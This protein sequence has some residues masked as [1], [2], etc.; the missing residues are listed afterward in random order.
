VVWDSPDA[1]PRKLF[2]ETT[3]AWVD[4]LGEPRFLPDGSFL[5]TSERNGWKHLYHYA[6][7]GK[8]LA[9]GTD[10]SWE[11]DN[12][13]R[14]DREAKTVYF[15]ARIGGSTKRDLC[16]AAI[17]G[18]KNVYVFTGA[19][20]HQVSLAPAGP[21]FIDRFTD[22]KTPTQARLEEIDTTGDW[23]PKD[24]GN[25]VI[26]GNRFAVAP[27]RVRVLDNNPAREKEQFE[28]GKYER[29]KVPMGDGFELE[30]ALV[31]PPDFDPEKKYPIWVFTYAGPN[32]P[33]IRDGFGG[34]R[35]KEQTLATS[36]IVVFRVDPRSA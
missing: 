33:T 15:T 2:R 18:S 23:P 1:K 7:G 4:D 20:H 13:L 22:D 30:G 10:G 28:F 29:V 12:V 35:G 16:G 32:T 14:G 31:Y 6:A 34:G 5:I 17:D 24:P 8:L 25:N 11:V 26:E 21:L 27:K 9:Q 3:K 36:G 19:G